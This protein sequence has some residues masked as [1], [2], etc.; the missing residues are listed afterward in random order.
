MKQAGQ[1]RGRIKQTQSPAKEF[2]RS[3]SVAIRLVIVQRLDNGRDPPT[4]KLTARTAADGM[5]SIGVPRQ[6]GFARQVADR[7]IFMANGH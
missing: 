7:V 1:W 6:M 3:N 2:G 4:S 5:A